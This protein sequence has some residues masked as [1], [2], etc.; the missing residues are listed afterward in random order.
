MKEAN[1]I[2]LILTENLRV[3]SGEAD[4][5]VAALLL[6]EVDDSIEVDVSTDEIEALAVLL[7]NVIVVDD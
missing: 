2:F 5:V 4:C 3:D 7:D 6:V 1:I